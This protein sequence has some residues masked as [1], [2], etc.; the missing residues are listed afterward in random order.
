VTTGHILEELGPLLAR[1][2][3]PE[4][5]FGLGIEGLILS[6]LLGLR[7]AHCVGVT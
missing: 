2:A 4:L 7:F 6:R 1:S 5:L 3:G